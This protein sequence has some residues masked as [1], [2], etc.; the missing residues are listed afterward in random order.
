MH[1]TRSVDIIVKYLEETRMLVAGREA[2]EVF[3]KPTI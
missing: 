2:Q 3:D 1:L